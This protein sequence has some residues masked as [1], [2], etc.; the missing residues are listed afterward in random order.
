MPKPTLSH[1]TLLLFSELDGGLK[2]RW[3]MDL[4]DLESEKFLVSVLGLNAQLDL[5]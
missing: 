4:R 3:L 1:N 2:N 5:K